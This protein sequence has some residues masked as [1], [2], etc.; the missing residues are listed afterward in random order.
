MRAQQFIPEYERGTASAKEIHQ[1]LHQAGYRKLGGGAEA[2][3]WA[4]DQG[5]VV[6]IIMPDDT[7][8][9]QAA[10][11]TFQDFYSMT[12]RYPSPHWP[13]FYEMQDEAGRS[14]VFTRFKIQGRPYMQIAMERLRPLDTIESAIVRILVD[15][16]RRHGPDA[17]WKRLSTSPSER[18]REVADRYRDQIEGLVQAIKLSRAQGRTLKYGWDLHPGNVMKRRNG[19]FVITDPWFGR[20]SGQ[21]QTPSMGL[22]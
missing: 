14:S 8:D 21:S 16:S 17:A 11:R 5:R 1:I 9:A 3:A 13:R 4:R 19:T 6:K 22:F 7:S 15:F 20:S 10:M 2:T 12:Q 18:V